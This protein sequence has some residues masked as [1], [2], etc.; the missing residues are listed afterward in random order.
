MST[1][2][3]KDTHGNDQSWVDR[4]DN[5]RQG[6]DKKSTNGSRQLVDNSR[7]GRQVIDK[8]DKVDKRG[9][10]SSHA[11]RLARWGH[12][13]VGPA[14]AGGVTPGVG[15]AH[16]GVGSRWRGLVSRRRGM[17]RWR[18][19]LP[20][21]WSILLYDTDCIVSTQASLTLSPCAS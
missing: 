3:D 9:S 8:V 14:H 17:S 18:G 13:G 12:A 7:Q 2:I 21:S 15:P 4:V 6:V 1:T 16:A 5:G 19:T 20:R 10:R 11:A